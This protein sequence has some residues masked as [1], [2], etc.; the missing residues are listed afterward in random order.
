MRRLSIIIVILLLTPVLRADETQRA[1]LKNLRGIIP[2]VEIENDDITSVVNQ[3]EIQKTVEQ[4]LRA[5]ALY[6]GSSTQIRQKP[7]P[8]ILLFAVNGTT[9]K[10][11]L[12]F[13]VSIDLID[14][15]YVERPNATISAST[16]QAS[17]FGL[18]PTD[19]LQ[20]LHEVIGKGIDEFIADWRAA[21]PQRKGK[22]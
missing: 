4:R 10:N 6:V 18:C 22:P 5:A 17:F 16:W 15:A 8:P 13:S 2:R 9:Y 12:A 19:D 7:T 11:A 3:S 21:N 1:A 14:E 20:L